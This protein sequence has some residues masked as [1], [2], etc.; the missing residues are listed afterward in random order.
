M[1]KTTEELWKQAL[2]EQTVDSD[3]PETFRRL[4]IENERES[5]EAVATVN[6]CRRNSIDWHIDYEELPTDAPLFTFPPAAIDRDSVIEALQLAHDHMRLYLSHYTEK[7]N[8]FNTVTR[9]LKSQLTALDQR[10]EVNKLIVMG[11]WEEEYPQ[12][13]QGLKWHEMVEPLTAEQANN[14]VSQL[15]KS[16]EVIRLLKEKFEHI[17]EY[18]NGDTNHAAMVDALNH[19]DDVAFEAIAA[20]DTVLGKKGE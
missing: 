6:H 2:A 12:F 17:R 7:H 9:A 10:D 1:R 3:V 4:V 14:L 16:A 5:A 8:V 18:W 19:I 13:T 11:F 15:R 20:I